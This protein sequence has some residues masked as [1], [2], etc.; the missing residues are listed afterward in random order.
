MDTL[1]PKERSERMSR[2]QAKNTKP[3][4]HV[5]RLISKLGYRYRLHDNK[6]PGKPD[7]VFKG[8]K[9]VVFVHGCFWHRHPDPKC[10]LARL[11]KSRKEF[12]VPK[13]TDNRRRD[14]KNVAEL[15]KNGWSILI[16]W[17]CQLKNEELLIKKLKGYLGK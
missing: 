13:L 9:K 16:I 15:R 14:I 2:V 11:P 17:E 1:N 8:R 4:L 5:R 10:A 6:L 12:W 7:I 3:E